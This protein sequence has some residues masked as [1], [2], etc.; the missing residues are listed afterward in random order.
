MNKIQDFNSKQL[1]TKNPEL[2]S[3]Y[4]VKIHQ[5]IKEGSKER[6]QVFEGLIIAKKHGNGINATITVR[7]VS[8]GIG[9]E[10][11]FPI[12]SPLIDKIEIVKKSKTRRA[13]LYYIRDL[14]AKQI[15]SKKK[16]KQIAE[17]IKPE[18]IGDTQEAEEVKE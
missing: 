17:I 13:K 1:K 2:Q 11:V 6:V 3:G 18:K 4:T 9:V 14:T 16:L 5:K 8:G 10:R 7:K 15:R 12:H